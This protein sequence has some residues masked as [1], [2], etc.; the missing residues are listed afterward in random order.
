MPEEIMDAALAGE[1][2]IFA[3]AGISTESRRAYGGT[4]AER[5]AGELGLKE[6]PSFPALMSAYEATHGR[7][8]LLQRIRARLD[9]VDAFPDLQR[10]VTRF[11][12]ALATAYFLRYVITTNWDTYFEDYAA[13]TPIVIPEDYA[14]SDVDGRKVF[15][16]HGSMHNLST[17]V[18]TDEDYK[19]CY[20]SLRVGIIGS[21]L[22][23]LLATKRV[24]FIGYSFGDP[25]LNRIL[26][27]LRKELAGVIPHSYLVTPHG[28][29]GTAFPAERVIRTDG[30]FF[31]ERMK[32]IA[33][34]RGVLRR[35]DAFR[36]AF[37]LSSRLTAAYKRVSQA[38]RVKETPAVV[39][40]LAYQDG[41]RHALDRIYARMGSG[42]YF[43]IH[44]TFHKVLGYEDI[45]KG[46]IR[47]KRYF[48]SAYADGY[49]TG[50]LTL[51]LSAQE[52]RR[53]P[54]YFVWGCR[55]DITTF[56]EFRRR[57]R[58]AET[59]HKSAAREARFLVA[60]I[61]D[62][63]TIYHEPFLDVERYQHLAHTA[64]STG[65]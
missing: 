1:L 25:D 60:D 50:L 36:R 29:Q 18:A 8:Q 15:K 4:F 44:A 30:S 31:I 47:A 52:I 24:V 56:A 45:R 9:Y 21:T 28:Y 16:L 37:A 2:L 35:N 7:R 39:H 12:H 3:G 40:A 27:F 33:V 14:F 51:S 6:M 59:L 19:R 43:D 64:R 38:Y 26:A 65:R 41:M 55:H 61:A 34:D 5:I 53:V 63:H 20:R 58:H 49:Q 22:R 11:H 48:D 23:H 13:A 32:E 46:A 54:L 42:E 17:I 10:L 62:D 57:L